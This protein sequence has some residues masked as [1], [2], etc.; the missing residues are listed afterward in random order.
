VTAS[1]KLQQITLLFSSIEAAA[2][3]AELLLTETLGIT[4]VQL[5]TAPPEISSKDSEYVDL[6]A[7]R[8]LKGEPMHYIVG[9]VEFHGLRINVGK[10]VL[11]P[12]PETELMAGEVIKMILAARR[13]QLLFGLPATD[14]A[15]GEW[16]V[17]VLDLCT[18]S[19]C[20]ALALA[21]EIDRASIVGI[22]VSDEA[23]SYARRNAEHNWIDNVT[24]LQ[25]DLFA[26]LPPDSTF[27]FI[28]SNPP[29]I[30]RKDI[31]ALQVEIRDYEPL[32]ALDGGEDGLDIYRRIFEGAPGFLTANGMLILEVGAGQSDDIRQLAAEAGFSDSGFIRDYS[33]IERIF[34]GKKQ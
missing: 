6:L 8:R 15:R 20:I 4:K 22:D 5:H 17:T 28:V 34:I 19:G 24:F 3:E 29:Y 30:R 2:K 13:R 31:A 27:D 18:G 23:L 21:Q 14:P 9:H 7:A 32:D 12:R 25:G 26:P 16:K 10:G 1:E 33:G 11:I